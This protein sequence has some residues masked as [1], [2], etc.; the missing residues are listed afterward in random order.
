MAKLTDDVRRAIEEI[1]PAAVATAGRDGKP[2][3]SVKGSARVV[4][5]ETVAFADVASPRTV[6][7][8]RENPRVSIIWSDAAHHRSCRI[9]GTATLVTSGNLFDE[10]ARELSARSMTVK[11][12]VAVTVDEVELT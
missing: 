12:V 9:W 3:V 2:N 5:D 7:N 6:A 11:N 10:L 8:I 4:D 1:H